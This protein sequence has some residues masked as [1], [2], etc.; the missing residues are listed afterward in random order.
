MRAYNTL[1]TTRTVGFPH[2]R[3][4]SYHRDRELDYPHHENQRILAIL[5]T[6]HHE[7]HRHLHAHHEAKAEIPA[8]II[9][10]APRPHKIHKRLNLAS[11]KFIRIKRYTP[12]VTKVEE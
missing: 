1:L 5:A 10:M 4:S 8:I 11:K 2:Q 9:V 3:V 6:T 7:D 12:A